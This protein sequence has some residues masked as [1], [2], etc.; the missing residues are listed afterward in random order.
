MFDLFKTIKTT[1]SQL[2]TPSTES[3]KSKA[4]DSQFF[5]RL[6]PL[7]P[8]HPFPGVRYVTGQENLQ[9]NLRAAPAKAGLEQSCLKQVEQNTASAP[10]PKTGL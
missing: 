2:M 8:R 5:G 10:T 3:S 9:A 1:F 7:T 6:T 4:H